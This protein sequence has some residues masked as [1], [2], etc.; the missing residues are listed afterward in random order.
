MTGWDAIRT[1][2]AAAPLRFSLLGAEINAFARWFEDGASSDRLE[3]V[4]IRLDDDGP[5]I[6]GDVA[7]IPIGRWSRLWRFLIGLGIRELELDPR[8]ESNQVADILTLLYAEHRNL[9]GRHPR[10]AAHPATL[11]RSA[12]GLAHACTVT[13]LDAGRLTV[14][15]SYCMTRFSHLVKWFKKRQTHLRD[16]RSLFRAAPRYAVLVGLGPMAVFFLYAFHNSWFLLLVTS[17]LGSVF[18]SSATY[19][20][21]MTVGSVEYDNEEQAHTLKQAYD[22]VKLY[23]DRIRSDMD[24]A[25]IVQ[26][27]LLPDLGSMPLAD[28]LE[29]A[30]S[31]AP[32]EEVGGDY[33]DASLTSEGRVAVIFADVSGHGLGAAVVTAIIKT[34]FEA[35]LEREGELVGLVQLLNR[36]LFD[37]TPNQSFAAVAVGVYDAQRSAFSYCNCGHSPYPYLITASS[38]APSPLDAAQMI[39][40]G[41]VPEV[42][43][44]PAT[45]DLQLGDTLIFA[46]DGITEAENDHEEEFGE[47]GLEDYLVRSGGA[48]LAQLVSGL[49]DAVESFSR[50]CE[51]S[52][53]R[54]V[55]S[56]RV[57]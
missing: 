6:R 19:L 42:D 39:I 25:R 20:F 15:Y 48:P 28:S 26:Q 18:M 37:L 17:L 5:T 8:L 54:T 57:R 52:D 40:L 4:Q 11:L 45:I 23:A 12:D 27:R 46:T 7:R 31:F 10:G 41:V 32:Q 1:R 34:T 29:W 14:S 50:G 21:F 30:A 55:L 51:Q 2:L 36:R 22:Q 53:D 47:E 13:R 49:V 16:H 9:R 3:A 33:F 38:G 44:L 43:P 35:W 56:L 24:R